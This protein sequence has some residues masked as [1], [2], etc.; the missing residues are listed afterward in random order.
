MDYLIKVCL[1]Q[2]RDQLEAQLYRLDYRM[3]EI[4]YVRSVIEQD[5]RAQFGGILERLK[6][7]EGQK[8]SVLQHMMAEVQQDI[9]AIN[10]LT[11]EFTEM[12]DKGNNPLEF[13]IKSPTVNHNIEFLMNKPFKREIDVVP[14][15]L[16]RELSSLR[17][18]IQQCEMLE[19]LDKLKKEIIFGVYS[20]VREAE[21]SVV[22]GLDV[23]ANEEL[24]QWA[25]LAEKYSD[26]L[27]QFQMICYY[28]GTP[29]TPETINEPCEVNVIKVP[30][31]NCKESLK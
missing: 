21:K 16:P 9:D 29:L 18:E 26:E 4:K 3:E 31:K 17:E 12:T 25:V 13:M 23:A 7:A 15:D 28:C 8:L 6:S 5:A 27:S 30:N 11:R 22:D 10:V 2:K 20:T 1:V 24:G 14:Y 19:N